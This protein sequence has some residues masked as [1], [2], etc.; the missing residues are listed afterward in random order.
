MSKD[1][2]PKEPNGLLTLGWVLLGL[3]LVVLGAV[4]WI[5]ID[6][7]LNSL[8]NAL[9]GVL[10][11]VFS[12]I[13]ST[14]VSSY[15]SRKQALS[16]Y[17]Q[18]ARPALRR[19]AALELSTTRVSQYVS[20]LEGNPVLN[21]AALQAWLQGLSGQMSLLRDQL[22]AATSDWRELLPSDYEEAR[23]VGQTQGELFERLKKLEDLQGDRA[24]EGVS[25]TS[26][27]DPK[28][29]ELQSEIAQLRRKLVAQA[30]TTSSNPFLVSRG[31]SN[32]PTQFWSEL[33]REG[34]D[35]R[36]FSED[37]SILRSWRSTDPI[38]PDRK[39]IAPWNAVDR[40][41]TDSPSE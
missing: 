12:I 11:F 20:S 8:E 35:W 1:A 17:E 34:T 19:V 5:S 27:L 37:G 26:A 32:S 7:P 16:E 2:S 23:A 25:D 21:E 33:S 31:S 18:L 9:F 13:G 14:I 4:V 39:P 29:A 28:L 3:A 41:T 40:P 24:V 10:T 38:D 36:T 22:A 6:R 30:A 15:F